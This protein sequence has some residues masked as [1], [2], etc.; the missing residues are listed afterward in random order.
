MTTKKDNNKQ[1]TW[2]EFTI[3]FYPGI[4]IGVRTY[5]Y[6]DSDLHVFYLPFVDFALEIGK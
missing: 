4:L 6:G 2:W 5:N 3:G 1:S